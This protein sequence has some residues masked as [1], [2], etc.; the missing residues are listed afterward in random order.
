MRL[1]SKALALAALATLAHAGTAVATSYYVNG[2][3]GSDTNSCLQP[4][5]GTAPLGP[6]KTIGGAVGKATLS[7][8]PDEVLVAGGTYNE[9]VAVDDGTA[10]RALE[11]SGPK[12]VIEG[13]DTIGVDIIDGASVE[14]FDIRS[15]YSPVQVLGPGSVLDNEITTTTSPVTKTHIYIQSFA[16][17]VL[18]EGNT[19]SDDGDSEQTGVFST[20][21]ASM[22]LTVRGNTFS[23]LRFP[24]WQQSGDGS[25]LIA[26]NEISGLH[27]SDATGILVYQG[28]PVIVGNRIHSPSTTGT[29][30]A[31][32][33][34]TNGPAGATLRRNTLEGLNYAL[35]TGNT[36]V[37][38]MSISMDGD[39]IT[40]ST[41]LA[42]SAF[43]TGPELTISATNV[44][45]YDNA[46]AF[47]LTD[48]SLTLDSS[49]LGD[50][51]SKFGTSTCAI[52]FSR[53]PA[54][55][56]PGDLTD[57]NDFQTTADP[58]FAGP[59]DYHL[60]PGSP[61]IDAGNPAAPAAGILDIDGGARALDATPACTGN[62]NRRDIGADEF[63][64]VQPDCTA[65]NT[66]LAKPRIK[67]ANPR[68]RRSRGRARFRFSA[69]EPGSTFRCKLDSGRFRPC[70]PPK[71]LRGLRRG[72][73]VLQVRATD[74][75]GNTDRSPARRVFRI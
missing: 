12:P 51:I 11:V 13:G 62:V 59:G 34:D 5:P 2:A 69:T 16:G 35:L 4:V 42:V 37:T 18:I 41:S 44:T 67:K 23:G 43:N 8:G 30:G 6:C 52:I 39:Q 68:I 49:I 56:T 61:M 3:T 24:V 29:S 17:N 74:K 53:G 26:D 32:V 40:G 64:P 36:G 66:R 38:P 73:H 22:N 21:T 7:S 1:L 25:P 46:T 19:L 33:A 71:T 9:G 10:L 54:T 14:G 70:V 57:C 20:A 50:P 27:G 31:F 47:S 15:A 58:L 60:L 28:T 55:G 45:A 75:A 65:P 63:A 48:S 72:R